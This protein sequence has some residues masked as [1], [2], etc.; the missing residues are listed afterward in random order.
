M[1]NTEQQALMRLLLAIGERMLESGADIHRIEDTLDRVGMAAGATHMNVFVITASINVT[2]GFG[3]DVMITNTRRIRREASTNFRVIESINN[4]SRRFCSGELDIAGFEELL[5][6]LDKPLETRTLY[7]GNALASGA[8]CV[9]F[10][11]TALDALVCAVIGLL[12]CAFKLH[13]A[14]KFPNRVI[15]NIAVSFLSGLVICLT[16]RVIPGLQ[17]SK[18]MIGDIM[19]L[20]PGIAITNALRDA[21]VGDTISGCLRLVESVLWAGALAVGFMGAM[22]VTAL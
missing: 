21:L 9:F 2:I 13:A 16:C 19:L 17:E 18:I 12:V 20:T 14:V 22:A 15:Y 6:E 10:G 4:A 11:G 1:N 7:I 3:E 5:R 8:L